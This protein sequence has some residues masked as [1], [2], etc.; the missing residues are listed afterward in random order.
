MSK[1]PVDTL[2]VDG[3]MAKR[4]IGGDSKDPAA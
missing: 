3:A 1:Y 4:M 2:V